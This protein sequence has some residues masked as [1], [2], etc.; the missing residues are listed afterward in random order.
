MSS[1]INLV[2][3]VDISCFKKCV[4]VAIIVQLRVNA[5]RLCFSVLG[6]SRSYQRK[7]FIGNFPDDSQFQDADV[8]IDTYETFS[9]RLYCLYDVSG[10]YLGPYD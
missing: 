3:C 6:R 10:L 7:T 9:P 4:V 1:S 8:C 5:T 2:S